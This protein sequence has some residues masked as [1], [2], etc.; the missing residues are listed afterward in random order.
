MRQHVDSPR[1]LPF[2]RPQLF[3]GT[4]PVVEPRDRRCDS[5]FSS[6]V[7]PLKQ[8][9][10]LPLGHFPECSF[11]L[12]RPLCVHRCRPPQ[13]TV[14]MAFFVVFRQFGRSF[15]AHNFQSSIVQCGPSPVG[16]C[17]PFPPVSTYQSRRSAAPKNV[18]PF[19][20]ALC[21]RVPRSLFS[22]IPLTKTHFLGLPRVRRFFFPARFPQNLFFESCPS[23]C[24]FR[25]CFC[26]GY[27]TVF[28]VC[29]LPPSL[30]GPFFD[31]L[32]DFLRL[33]KLPTK[34][35]LIPPAV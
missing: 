11:S 24:V 3:L 12:R 5:V 35:R 13:C 22:N 29:V 6:P 7:I 27:M 17:F 15:S 31:P 18:T 2:V 32:N 34:G 33:S 23:K 21:I 4:V 16:G 19:N 25:F 1:R 8:R 10:W 26:S 28:E 14:R 30:A 20:F 9:W